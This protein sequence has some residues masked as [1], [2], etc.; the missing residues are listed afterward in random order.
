M[1]LTCSHL[2]SEG[3]GI[4]GS[5]DCKDTGSDNDGNRELG[6]VDG[7]GRRCSEDMGGMENM[8]D[9]EDSHYMH[10]GFTV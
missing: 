5:K 9:K 7:V 2:N 6:E 3:V 4:L 10:A 8:E 1:I